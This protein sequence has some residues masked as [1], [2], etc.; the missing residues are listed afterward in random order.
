MKL[1]I[2]CLMILITSFSQQKQKPCDTPENRAFDFWI[3]E[4][5]VKDKEG[6]VVYGHSKIERV[7]GDCVLLE[8]WTS[9]SGYTGKS[10][11]YYNKRIKKWEQ[12]WIG[13][14]GNP[15]EFKGDAGKET[16]NYTATTYNR[17][18]DEIQNK[19]TFTKLGTDLVRQHWEQ[20]PDTGKTWN[21]VF[22]GYYNRRMK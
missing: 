21:T 10:L 14:D 3:G 6:K 20:S 9:K 8:N 1:I 15:I 11:N 22:D 4:W 7:S 13:A 19:L 2:L 12:K 5:D 18:G 16:M 17:N